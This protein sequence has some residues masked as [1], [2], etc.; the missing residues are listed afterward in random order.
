MQVFKFGGASI[1]DADG[2]KN[3]GKILNEYK[4]QPTVLIVSAS[5]KMT[6]NLE[7]VANAYFNKTGNAENLLS[8][9]KEKHFAILSKLLPENH[10]AFD[11]LNNVF[12]EIHWIL[13]EEPH[14][15]YDYIYD[16]IVSIG[17]MVSTK[18]LS[19]YLNFIN[20]KTQWLDARDLIRTDNTHREGKVDWEVSEKMIKQKIPD[21]LKNKFVMTQ[22]FLG[23]T[24]ENYTATLGREGSDYSAAILAYALDA[25]NVT[26]WKDVPGVLNADPRY[27][28]AVQKLDLISYHEAIEMTYYG[29]SVIHP[30]TIKP[31]QNKNIPLYVRS[32]LQPEVVG[33]TIGETD[34]IDY[35]PV[36]VLKKNQI[37]ISI[38]ATDFSFITEENLSFIFSLFNRFH[39]KIN[40]M[41]NSAISFSVCVDDSG[42]KTKELIDELKNHFKVLHNDGLD[43]L[44]IRHY[45]E[46]DILTQ[47]FK[48]EIYL[49]QKSRST[50]QFVLEKQ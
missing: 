45:T 28:K 5:G 24:I 44:T 17:E 32:F 20:L 1:K 43:L 6:N 13:E 35:P 19:A 16:Q 27:F 21:L 4:N 38:S 15:P 11:E 26:I 39:A 18:M 33:T 37:L 48:R 9:I 50:A 2:F 42:E 3:V 23:G 31:L 22:G 46:A 49:E 29:A 14:N 7:E 47:T 30:K 36:F 8:I 34:F 12:V 10:A 25:K 41:Q 40:L